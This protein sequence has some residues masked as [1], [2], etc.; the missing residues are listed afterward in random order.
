MELPKHAVKG[1][2]QRRGSAVEVTEPGD[3]TRAMIPFSVTGSYELQVTAVRVSGN[4]Q[5]TLILP[6][7]STQFEMVC[8]HA[9]GKSFLCRIEGR[10]I[11]IPWHVENGR[12]F[13]VRVMVLQN[14]EMVT[15]KVAL[16]G[17]PL[18]SWEGPAAKVSLNQAWQLPAKDC[19]GLAALNSVALYKSVRLR[20][21]PAEPLRGPAQAP[22]PNT[23][24]G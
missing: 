18:L 5:L 14:Q 12:E 7:N 1:S 4:E 23:H 20:M 13:D 3:C 8:G 16:D 10:D 22:N 15:I 21:L 19:V 6:L 11:S 24:P 2:W 17:K 9:N